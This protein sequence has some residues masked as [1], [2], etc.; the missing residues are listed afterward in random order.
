MGKGPLAA[1]VWSLIGGGLMRFKVGL[2]VL[3]EAELNL[4]FQGERH[5]F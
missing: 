4:P 1:I 2:S 5:A 3:H